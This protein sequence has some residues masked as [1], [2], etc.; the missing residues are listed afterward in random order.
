MRDS[1]ARAYLA[2][3]FR[4]HGAKPPKLTIRRFR[5]YGWAGRFVPERNTIELAMSSSM[6]ED[7]QRAL[8]VHEAGHGLARVVERKRKGSGL[9]LAGRRRKRRR[10]TY[11]GQHNRP[12]YGVVRD[13]H[14]RSGLAPKTA[15]AIE[16]RSGYS[17]PKSWRR[18]VRLGK[19]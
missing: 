1:T 19:W 18:A 8:L 9:T 11:H 4:R 2:R 5:G 6:T 10:L 16:R 3:V 7:E 12:F 13:L 14:R 15:L 17:P